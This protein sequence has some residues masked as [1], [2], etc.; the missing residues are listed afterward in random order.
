MTYYGDTTVFGGIESL[1]SVN[2]P[3]ALFMLVYTL[4]KYCDLCAS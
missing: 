4:Q 2:E 3:I 1:K